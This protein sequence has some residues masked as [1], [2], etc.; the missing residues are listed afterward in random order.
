M[1]AKTTR[2]RAEMG[3][4]GQALSDGGAVRGNR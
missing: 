1:I 2:P 4:E 3:F